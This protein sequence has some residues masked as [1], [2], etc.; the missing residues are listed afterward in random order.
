[1]KKTMTL[2]L[3]LLSPLSFADSATNRSAWYLMAELGSAKSDTSKADLNA[4]L[5][6]R[7]VNAQVSELDNKDTA[8]GLHLGYRLHPHLALEL[9]YMDLGKREAKV[10]GRHGDT[11]AF[12]D[13]VS[14]L[15]PVTGD[16][17]SIALASAWSQS[18]LPC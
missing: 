1:M 8:W 2:A 9:G 10:T 16:G 17:V 11:Q 12:Y 14:D 4:V 15:Y 5:S 6:G 3:C 13:A 18:A 7:G